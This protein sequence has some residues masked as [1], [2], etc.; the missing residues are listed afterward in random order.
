[1]LSKELLEKRLTDIIDIVPN[2][3][4]SVFF[5]YITLT[6]NPQ[7]LDALTSYVTTYYDNLLRTLSLTPAQRIALQLQRCFTYSEYTALF[8][9]INQLRLPAICNVLLI[10]TE[11]ER[12]LFINNPKR[13]D[14]FASYVEFLT[15]WTKINNP[16]F[17]SYL[18]D[19]HD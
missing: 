13:D 12:L 19:V 4:N 1:M 10:T 17:H 8:R 18:H 3:T 5:G 2:D 16:L 14:S 6:D 11:Q 15:S 7:L 9:P